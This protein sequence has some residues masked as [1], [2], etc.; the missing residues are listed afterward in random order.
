MHNMWIILIQP[1]YNTV[2][3]STRR[4]HF[5]SARHEYNLIQNR[6]GIKNNIKKGV[7]KLQFDIIYTLFHLDTYSKQVNT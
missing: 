5:K 3:G 1:R 6:L 7:S 4:P 2:R